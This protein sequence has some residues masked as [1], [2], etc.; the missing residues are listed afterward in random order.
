MTPKESPIK[1]PSKTIILIHNNKIY[2]TIHWPNYV[3]KTL[4]NEYRYANNFCFSVFVRN[5]I[6]RTDIFMIVWWLDLSPPP[7]SPMLNEQALTIIKNI[8]IRLSG[9]YITSKINKSK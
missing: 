6:K 4:Y 7:P 8:D 1:S 5:I 2:T 9:Y 3:F